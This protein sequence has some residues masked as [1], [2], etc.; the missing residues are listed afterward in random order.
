M[1]EIKTILAGMRIADA[2]YNL[3]EPNDKIAVGISGGKDS[4]CLFYALHLYSKFKHTK[5]TI[6]PIILNLGFPSF[7]IS[8]IQTY[9]KSLGYELIIYDASTV[10]PILVANQNDKSHLPCSICSKMKKACINKAAKAHKCNKVAFAHHSTDAVETLF[11]NEIYGGRIATF[12]PKMNLER[13]NITFIRP[14]ILVDEK[15][16]VSACKSENIVYIPSSC[17][18]D[19]HTEREEIKTYLNKLYIKFPTAETNFLTMLSNNECLDIWTNKINNHLEGS[20]FHTKQISDTLDANLYYSFL[21]KHDFLLKKSFELNELKFLIYKKDKI[22]GTYSYI[23]ENN[24]III[25]SLHFETK[26]CE[27]ESLDSIMLHIEKQIFSKYNPCIIKTKLTL[28][29]FKKNYLKTSDYYI[30]N[31]A[32]KLSDV[33]NKKS[34]N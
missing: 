16:I 18:A 17:P 31:C 1:N 29:Y 4:M 33:L 34:E 7:N 5:F 27:K 20:L 28:P 10:Y 8:P 25:N 24:I 23:V 14:F 12:S 32:N 11:L 19:K 13:D 15:L 26:E 2:K 22:I 30:L 21:F 3:I 9:I 6:V